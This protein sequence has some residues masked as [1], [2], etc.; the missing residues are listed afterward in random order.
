MLTE[1][2]NA[3]PLVVQVRRVPLGA[4]R[5]LRFGMVLNPEYR[6]EI[7]LEGNV[8]RQDSLSRDHAGPR[9]V[10]NAVERLAGGYI[11][12]C[13][14]VKQDLEI[15][16][17]QHRDYQARLGQSFAHENYMT[18]L[19]KLRDQLKIGLSGVEG[20][21]SVPEL[22]ERIK[23]LRAGNT[24]EAASSERSVKKLSAEEPVT[25]RILRRAEAVV[26]DQAEATWQDMIAEEPRRVAGLG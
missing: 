3:M 22:A 1:K 18:E 5:G 14:R 15:A 10:L 6:P 12:E 25:A 9:A 13:A 20:E 23:A 16:E 24:I 19:A 7:Y 21:V 8:V 2:L 26:A 4:Y 11:V 17:N